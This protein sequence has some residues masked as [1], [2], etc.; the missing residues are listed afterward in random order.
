MLTREGRTVVD[1]PHDHPGVSDPEYRR[2][3]AEIAGV[4]AAYR[5][6]DPI[7]DV[8]Y[9]R[10][11]HAVWRTV[12]RRLAEQHRRFAVAEYLDGAR[13]VSTSHATVCRNYASS[14]VARVDSPGSASAQCPAWFRRGSSTALLA[15]RTF[16]STQYLRHHS[17]PFYTP[18][19]DLIHEIIGHGATL[20]SP[21]FADLYE[22]A[23]RASLRTTSE[24]GLEYFSRVFWFTLEFGVVWEDGEMR[25][26]GA[27]LLS[28]YGE[29]QVFRDAEIRPWNL[30]EMGTL[31]Y[32][33]SVYQPVL[34]AASSFEAMASDLTTFF[35]SADFDALGR[36]PAA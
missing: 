31:E 11:E 20:A 7:P 34:F 21:V 28:S 17:A 26:Y 8:E 32:D 24:A 27:G 15:E 36:P 25:A 30:H 6:G 9:T 23:G 16:L 35:E 12:S 18:E 10:A 5:T 2:R 33:I 3:R 22:A 13:G 14:T 1:L 4:G 29:I 19:P